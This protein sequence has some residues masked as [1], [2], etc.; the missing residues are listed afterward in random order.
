[1]Q[2]DSQLKTKKNKIWRFFSAQHF[3]WTF[4]LCWKQKFSR[5]FDFHLLLFIWLK[6]TIEKYEKANFLAIQHLVTMICN[7]TVETFVIIACSCTVFWCRLC[8]WYQIIEISASIRLKM[9]GWIFYGEFF[10]FKSDTFQIFY[11]AKKYLHLECFFF[12]IKEYPKNT[13]F[14]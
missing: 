7:K 8:A 14:D 6:N 5:F 9:E 12:V 1:M 11:Q 4:C 10:P 13:Y 2:N 3:E